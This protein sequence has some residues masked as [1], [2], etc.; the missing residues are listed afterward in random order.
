[1][2]RSKPLKEKGGKWKKSIKI[3]EKKRKKRKKRKKI[4]HHQIK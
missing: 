4:H 3:N 2:V 1:L